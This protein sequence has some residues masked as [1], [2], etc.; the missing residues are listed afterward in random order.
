MDNYYPVLIL[1]T[2]KPLRIPIA[3]G[4]ERLFNKYA[5]PTP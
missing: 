5:C 4:T 2:N 3:I 1:K